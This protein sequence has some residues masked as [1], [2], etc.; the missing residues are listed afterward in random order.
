MLDSPCEAPGMKSSSMTATVHTSVSPSNSPCEA[1]GMKSSSMK[2]A[3]VNTSVSPS[4]FSFTITKV[5]VAQICQSIG[6]GSSQSLAL[7][8][9]TTV[10]TTYLQNLAKL[11]TNKA[12]FSGRTQTNLFD[13]IYAIEDLS[14]IQGFHGASN[15]NQTLL[16][17]TTLLDIINFVKL[18]LEIPFAKPI[19]R[20]N[21]LNVSILPPKSP[22]KLH[23]DFA[24]EPRHSHIPLWLPSFPHRSAYKTNRQDESAEVKFWLRDCDGLKEGN[25]VRGNADAR[26]EK[27]ERYELAAKRGKVRFGLGL[28]LR[29]AVCGGKKVCW[30]S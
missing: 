3:T 7:Q 17:S 11:A 15:V 23:D 14:S 25:E 13:V 1:R 10:A 12:T 26:R 4:N 27:L 9:L 22:C 29:N 16:N 2:T 20:H 28:G 21:P 8:T 5:A 30:H 24:L 18:T 19:P 6:F